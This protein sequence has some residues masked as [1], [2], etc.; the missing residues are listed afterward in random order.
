[1]TAS[2]RLYLVDLMG[3]QP[4][5]AEIRAFDF[6]QAPGL[7]SPASTAAAPRGEGIGLPQGSPQRVHARAA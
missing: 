2:A 6:N 1:M 5:G 4:A 7:V 3:E